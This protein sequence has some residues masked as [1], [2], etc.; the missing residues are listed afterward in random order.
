MPLIGQTWTGFAN[1]LSLKSKGLRLLVTWARPDGLE[2]LLLSRLAREVGVGRYPNTNRTVEDYAQTMVSVARNARQGRSQITK[3]DLV[4]RTQ[5]RTDF[6]SVANAHPVARAEDRAVEV[7]RDSMVGWLT[8]Q[9]HKAKSAR[10]T[11][12]VTGPPGHGKSW[13]CRQVVDA[14]KRKDW[15]VA[16][17]YCFLGE[18]DRD[19][20]VRVQAESVFGSI[21]KRLAEQVPECLLDQRPRFAADEATVLNGIRKVVGR[22]PTRPAAIV[23]DGIDHV[24]RV[25]KGLRGKD[26]APRPGRSAFVS[27]TYP[28]G[29][30]LVVVSQQG[31]HLSPLEQAG[32]M[33]I[34]LPGLEEHELRQLA[35][36]YGVILGEGNSEARGDAQ[37]VDESQIDDF[38]QALL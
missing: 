22:N 10:K 35:S 26:P 1:D 7:S 8:D 5:L 9:L 31:S 36:R 4:Q 17:H 16:E 23:I 34:S 19:R 38:L 12:I 30:V 32:A 27:S 24:A 6:G 11:V 15:I 14:L 21:L 33:Q 2:S 20:D 29:S 13:A 25:R 28:A 3:V 18:N 37:V